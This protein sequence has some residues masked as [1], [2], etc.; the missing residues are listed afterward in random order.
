VLVTAENETEESYSILFQRTLSESTLITGISYFLGSSQYPLDFHPDTLTY[1]VILPYNNPITHTVE[2][3]KDWKN[4][5]VIYGQPSNPFG[6]GT[7]LVISE[8]GAHNLTYTVIFQRKGNAHL[9]DLYYTLDGED[10]PIPNFSPTTF[11]YNISL[12]LC[13]DDIPE[14]VYIPE[15]NRCDIEHIAQTTPNG[16]S[17]VK[18][19][20]WNEDD[21]VTYTVNF[22]VLLSTEALLSDLQVNGV[23]I[24]NFV[25]NTFHYTIPQY[26]YGT[27]LPV[28][29]GDVEYCDAT[30]AV[31]NIEEFPGTASV[32]VT[33]GNLSTNTYTVSFSIE[34]GDNNYLDSLL[35]NGVLWWSFE[36]D[37]YYYPIELDYGTTEYPEVV[38]I[39]EDERAIVTNT[40]QEEGKII[41]INVKAL[42]GDV[43]I[44]RV[45]FSIEGNNNALAK[46]IYVDWEPIE[47]FDK[48]ERNYTYYLKNNY[49]GIPDVLAETED[50]NALEPKYEVNPLLKQTKIIIT[51][52]NG[53]DKMEYSITFIPHNSINTF[54]GET[55]I[56]VYP[57]PSSNI[58]HIDIDKLTGTLEI[59][60]IEGKIMGIHPLQAGVN[61]ISIELLQNGIYFYKIFTDQTMI[62]AGKFIKN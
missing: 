22:T 58:I 62:G 16:T 27:E 49:F 24:Q 8:N 14:L 21:S 19:V 13:T 56:L 10:F 17:S 52:E 3:T 39:P 53:I 25:P 9:V 38:G 33:A 29:S 32:I 30:M 26:L 20:T 42:N 44:Y 57:N 12:P 43:A 28:V 40:M 23:S 61:A 4:T 48:F 34:A 46:M 55:N 2:A 60:S 15:D 1:Y 5:D 18:L 54:D 45:E 7:I 51:A 36:K 31:N 47:D 6:T 59:Y 11:I 41:I 50:P 37:K 35:I